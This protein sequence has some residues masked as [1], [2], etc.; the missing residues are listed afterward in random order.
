MLQYS[1]YCI[2]QNVKQNKIKKKKKE[3]H[4]F[5]WKKN[6]KVLIR[7][8]YLSRDSKSPLLNMKAPCKYLSQ[9]QTLTVTL[10]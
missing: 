1:N 4:F 8:G 7:D 2:F 6:V 5:T 9:K 3:K 10:T